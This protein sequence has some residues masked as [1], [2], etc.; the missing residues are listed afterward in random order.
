MHT[1]V[2]GCVDGRDLG[3]PS[4][5]DS[6]LLWP[7]CHQV[8][9]YPA[10]LSATRRAAVADTLFSRPLAAIPEVVLPVRQTDCPVGSSS[11][12]SCSGHLPLRSPITPTSFLHVQ[13]PLY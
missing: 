4:L 8:P 7:M 3:R 12:L 6:V 11:R 5:V 9:P 10:S 1:H 2:P 13:N